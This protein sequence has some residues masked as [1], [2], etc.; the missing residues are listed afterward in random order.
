MKRARV[1]QMSEEQ[2]I[3]TD[4]IPLLSAAVM[5]S[6][7]LAPHAPPAAAIIILIGAHPCFVPQVQKHGK[8]QPSLAPFVVFVVVVSLVVL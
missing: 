4:A 5:L 8:L 3:G 7:L 2:R 6:W 1:M